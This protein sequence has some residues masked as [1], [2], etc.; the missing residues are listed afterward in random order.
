[1][2]LYSI[3]ERVVGGVRI[4][5]LRPVLASHAAIEELLA[6][7][8]PGMGVSAR[9]ERTGRWVESVV[10]TGL[11]P[12]NEDEVVEAVAIALLAAVDRRRRGT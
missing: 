3:V 9:V 7:R 10:V 2:E 8:L 4:K 5:P 6:R 1:M 11:G 12:R